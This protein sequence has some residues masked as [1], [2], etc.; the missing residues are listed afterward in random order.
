MAFAIIAVIAA[1]C[2][3]LMRI[4]VGPFFV[5]LLAALV[6]AGCASTPQ[7]PQPE[8]A[9][10]AEAALALGNLVFAAQEYERLA[11]SK[12]G[13]REHYLL[14]AAEAWR[15]EGEFGEVRRVLATI[16]R[17]NLDPAQNLQVDLLLAE[18]LLV[19][20]EFEQ[21]D[22]LLTLP[23]EQVPASERSRILELRAK[24]LAGSGRPIDA[25][26]ERARLDVLLDPSERPANEAAVL[27]LLKPLKPA[28]LS[29]TLQAIGASD[30]RRP[31]LERSLREHGAYP[32][33]AELRPS[34]PVG[35]W[36]TNA[37]GVASAEGYQDPGRI[38]LLLPLSGDYAAAGAAVRDGFMAGW[39]ATDAGSRAE[40]R[41]YDTGADPAALQQA[42]E[43]AVSEGANTLVGPLER[44]QVEAVFA[45]LPEAVTVLALNQSEASAVPP[46]GHYQ[47]GL[48]PEEEAAL[49]A[50]R[51]YD[52][53]IRRTAIIISQEDW[54]DRASRAFAAQ[55]SALGGQV[56]GERR[57]APGAV[58]FNDELDALVGAPRFEAEPVAPSSGVDADGNP[59]PAP[60]PRLIPV[61]RADGP[62]ALFV[63]LRGA[64]GRML[65]PQLRVRGQDALIV[66][67]T[68]HIGSGSSSMTADRD[69]DGL[70]F[71]DA[72][73]LFDSSTAIGVSRDQLGAALPTA[74]S[75]SRLFAFGMD[76]C[77]LL[78]FLAHLRAN[79]GSYLAGASGQLLVD[80]FG[81]V[82]RLPTGYRFH[83][84]L[85]ILSES[86]LPV[87]GVRAEPAV[88][89]PGL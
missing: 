62:E 59:L 10:S 60:K 30:R 7:K 13:L 51:L 38:G 20:G 29:E 11:R 85:P 83:N 53:G 57:V 73:F 79:E 69:L 4:S 76:A 46:A 32:A 39:F 87:S 67:A 22:A 5:P 71:L 89:A 34:A 75:S 48:A 27:A 47:F 18:A 77:R 17:K 1:K 8:A 58:K 16:K 23:D 26:N 9:Q 15:D 72:P 36:M 49:A 43:R 55:F 74:T 45:A 86:L 54:A 42:V 81:R 35:A 44:S 78:P 88:V 84:G 82:R 21:A 3:L 41:I 24:A 40:L 80:G 70:S 12:R 63:A 25:M 50:E 68:S 52:A 61:L 65:M 19:Q 33:R 14:L 28:L 37:D 56:L 64:Q 66:L 2:E 6:L 31:W